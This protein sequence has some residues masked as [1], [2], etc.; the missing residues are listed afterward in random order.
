R[1]DYFPKA[2]ML[3]AVASQFS[4]LYALYAGQ[5]SQ[6]DRSDLPMH[7]EYEIT[8]PDL[9]GNEPISAI[10]CA[11]GPK[12]IV[13]ALTNDEKFSGILGGGGAKYIN[14]FF[15]VDLATK[16]IDTMAIHPD[17]HN[18]DC[19]S[20]A[21]V[22]ETE[23]YAVIHSRQVACWDGAQWLFRGQPPLDKYE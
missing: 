15:L 23:A 14:N 16:E 8:I 4:D 9:R 21:M 3:S 5:Q 18:P 7:W 10:A 12:V 11:T 1:P 2:M 17:L 20:I 6:H 22:S 19:S 13:S